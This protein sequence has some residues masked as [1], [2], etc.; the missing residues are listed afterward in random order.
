LGC[1]RAGQA[2]PLQDTF[3]CSPAAVIVIGLIVK[4]AGY[5]KGA[6]WAWFVMFAIV[7]VRAFPVL[8]LLY[9]RQWRGEPTIAQSFA[10]SISKSGLARNFV[11]VLL[12]FLLM[13]LGLVLPVKTFVLG[14]GGGPGRSGRTNLGAPDKRTLP[15]I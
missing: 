1:P 2:L 3:G 13:V 10:S 14:R 5:I 8:M 9:L 6:R 7:W 15:E 12:I 4:W 11:E